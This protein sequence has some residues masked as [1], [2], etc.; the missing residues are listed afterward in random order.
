[1]E[2]PT[3]T[4]TKQRLI[5]MTVLTLVILSFISIYWRL[6]Q[7]FADIMTLA[8][9]PAMFSYA[10]SYISRWFCQRQLS[11]YG[12]V[13]W[14]LGD[15]IKRVSPWWRNIRLE[16]GIMNNIDSWHRRYPQNISLP[17]APRS[18]MRQQW[19]KLRYHFLFYHDETKLMTNKQ[20]LAI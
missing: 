20:I 18:L 10:A 17:E 9:F 5:L 8:V 11:D 13:S 15:I 16:H 12:L 2:K 7:F 6:A 14:V 3:W 4:S 19:P 1:M